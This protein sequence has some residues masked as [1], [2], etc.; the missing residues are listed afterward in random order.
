MNH[1]FSCPRCGRPVKELHHKL[2]EKCHIE[3]LTLIE[4]PG[5]ITITLCPKCRAYRRGKN[6][7]KPDKEKDL[8]RIILNIIEENIKMHE[9]AEDPKVRLKLERRS[10]STCIVKIHA[11]ATIYNNQITY[12]DKFTLHI[13]RETCN[14]CSRL[15]GG[16]YEA[17]IQLRGE[18]QIPTDKEIKEYTEKINRLI[19]KIHERGDRTAFI[20]KTI[21]RKEGPDFYIGSDKA[22]RQIAQRITTEDGATLTKS[23]KLIGKRDGREIYRVT[24]ALRLPNL[25]KG[26][27]LREQHNTLQITR[28]GKNITT[29]NLQNGTKRTINR[30]EMKNI[31]KIAESKDAETAIVVNI[32]KNSIQILDPENYRTHTIKKPPFISN[33]KKEVKILRIENKILIIN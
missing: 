2:C 16:Y 32:D 23:P 12:S 5:V 25:K 20:T 24:Y 26:D 14:T 27:I 33:N 21:K 29:I 30:R 18:N 6:W 15:A 9:D 19:E 28:T 1:E 11:D 22:A 8:N 13:H 10:N 17:I 4:H 3:R 31:R 7:T